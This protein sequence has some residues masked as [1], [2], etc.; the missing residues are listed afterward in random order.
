MPDVDAHY[1]PE[2]SIM[3]DVGLALASLAK[4][5]GAEPL[6]SAG[7]GARIRELVEA[8]LAKGRESDAFPLKPQRIVSDI[9]AAM[10]DEDI[11]L[12]DTGAIKMWMAR[13]YPTYAPL[14]CIVSN[15]LSTMTPLSRH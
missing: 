13:L 10:G 9:R 12:A 15:G 11:V 14:T 8:E 4:E 5:L 1:I 2:I 7:R 6:L 3:A